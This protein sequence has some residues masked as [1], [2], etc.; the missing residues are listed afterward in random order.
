MIVALRTVLPQ[1]GIPCSQKNEFAFA[2]QSRY[3]LLVRSHDPVP[4]FRFLQALFKFAE[5]SGADSHLHILS[6]MS[7]AFYK[8]IQFLRKARSGNEI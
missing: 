2:F 6:R 7:S 3:Y 5:G 4:A 8:L 1:P